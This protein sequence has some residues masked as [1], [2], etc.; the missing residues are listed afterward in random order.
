MNSRYYDAD[1]KRFTSVDPVAAFDVQKASKAGPQALNAYTYVNNNPIKYNDPTGEYL[2]TAVDVAFLGLSINEFRNNP[3]IGNAAFVALDGLGVALPVPALVGAVRHGG[4]LAQGGGQ[5][6]QKQI[7]NTMS[8]VDNVGDSRNFLLGNTTNADL[9]SQINQLYKPT[10][11][12]ADGSSMSV[13]KYEA[14]TGHSLGN[15]SGFTFKH[16]D[17]VNQR[18]NGKQKGIN[19]LINSGNLS[20]NDLG[21]ARYLKNEM[22]GALDKV[23]LSKFKDQLKQ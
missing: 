22:Q 23:E 6:T 5:L 9:K 15:S 4:N 10:A 18:L 8:Q 19:T 17:K 16:Y 1:L 13:L 14:V 21:I 3:T 20:G 11:G 2:E 7:K 12:Y